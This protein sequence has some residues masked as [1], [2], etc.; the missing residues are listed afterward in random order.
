VRWAA[1][2]TIRRGFRDRLRSLLFDGGGDRR[3][4]LRRTRRNFRGW[5]C[6]DSFD[7]LFGR[8]GCAR[9]RFRVLLGDFS[10]E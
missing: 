3:L 7:R 1:C 5:R 8:C 9:F 6:L 2:R 4:H 10:A